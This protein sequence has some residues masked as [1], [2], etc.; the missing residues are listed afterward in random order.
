MDTSRDP[1][2][3]LLAGLTDD[4]V[5]DLV[6][7]LPEP[8]ITA[9]TRASA[10]PA[11]SAP[12]G[13][14]QQAQELDPGYRSRPHLEYL[15]GRLAAAVAD[16]E[17]G[18]SRSLV[19][20]LPPRSGK[21]QLT[22]V[23]LPVWL[24]RKHPDWRVGILSHSPNL[25]A[26]WGRQVRRV[27]ER[28]GASLGLGIARDAGAVSEWETTV[29]GGV[30]SRSV[31]QAIS[32]V[33][34]RVL[35]VDDPVR[36]FAGAHS[37]VAREALW[38]WWRA[39]AFTRLEHPYLAVVTMTRWHADD[40]TAR[41]LSPEHEGNP[42]DWE[43][44]VLPA[45]AGE[46][47]AL[48]RV[49]GEPLLSPIID[50]TPGQALER[51]SG[52][53]DAVGSYVWQA[54]YQQD[55]APPGGA[56][57]NV[58]AFRYWT[59]DPVLAAQSGAV[60]LG[61]AELRAGEFVDSWDTSFKGSGTSDYVVGQRWARVGAWRVL[62]AQQRG[63]WSFTEAVAAMRRWAAPDAGGGVSPFGDRVFV[64]LVEDSANGPAI[65]DTLKDEVRGVRGVRAVGSKGSRYRA[66]TP[67]VERGDV[68][69]PLPSA[70]GN[71]WVSGLLGELREAP[72]G[73]H[74]DQCL[75]GATLVETPDGPVRLMDVR[76]GDVVLGASGWVR[77]LAAACTGSARVIGSAGLVGTA[78]HPVWTSRG[79]SPLASLRYD[80]ELWM[81]ARFPA[82]TGQPTREAGARHATGGGSSSHT[83]GPR[84]L[85]SLAAN[86]RRR[87]AVVARSRAAAP[88]RAAYATPA[89]SAAMLYKSR[90]SSGT[91][92]SSADT[93]TRP[94][95]PTAGITSQVVD[96][97]RRV[98]TR[99]T[100]RFTS[101]RL[102]RSR[103]AGTCTTS[104]ETRPTTAR[105]TSCRS[106][107]ASTLRSRLLGGRRVGVRG[108][109]GTRWSSTLRRSAL[110]RRSGTGPMR[111][112]SG[113]AST[114]T[115]R[116]R[117][118]VPVFN[119]ATGD[120]TYFA[121]GV[122]VHNCDALA[123][124][125][126]F[127]GDGGGG[128]VTVPGGVVDRPGVARV[129]GSGRVRHRPAPGVLPVGVRVRRGPGSQHAR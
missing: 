105:R 24:L 76:T 61:E 120:G 36:D 15:S 33:G 101:V 73:S 16:V 10:S 30:M 115:G 9:M 46:G 96:R 39:N 92:S 99:C 21:S 12:P 104:T 116:F 69:L 25:A 51:W 83:R 94:T 65:I 90:P 81:H 82:A 98:S 11:G 127:F 112:G 50:E 113:T 41:I 111:A 63:Q 89:G 121:N 71:G 58:G 40:I 109:T 28:H 91:A 31:G 57:F 2:A 52:V 4:Q 55:P 37:A 66:V 35:L 14:L 20:G 6:A 126:L 84:R 74:D 62:V 97:S 60:L 17:A 64:R 100:V 75:I 13:P 77:V 67:E 48:G 70:P 32:G 93:P 27:V 103:M 8:V 43:Q 124:A 106:R 78:G 42:D 117:G 119:L 54:L 18:R 129:V 44:I 80:D 3:G 38:E 102:G 7:S 108:G 88:R 45:I 26:S 95:Q 19:V 5:A 34:F 49:P 79:W 107:L 128:V 29:G 22:S 59:H 85:R 118:R 47:D 56:I 110:A 68:L 114:P 86:S 123:Q 23:Y 72:H 53:R 122:L 87:C 125:L 1:L